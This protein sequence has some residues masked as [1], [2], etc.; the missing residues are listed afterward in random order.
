VDDLDHD[1]CTA[2]NGYR[3]VY[4]GEVTCMHHQNSGLGVGRGAK[5]SQAAVGSII[6]NDIKLTYKH[7]KNLDALAELAAAL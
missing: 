1:L 2:L 5:L 4:C 6:G 7:A 3:I